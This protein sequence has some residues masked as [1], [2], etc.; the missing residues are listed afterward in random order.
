MLS[1]A[2]FVGYLLSTFMEILKNPPMSLQLKVGTW[3][4]VFYAVF[5]PR[6]TETENKLTSFWI[7]LVLIKHTNNPW[8]GCKRRSYVKVF[9][10]SK[11]ANKFLVKCS[12]HTQI[13]ETY[14]RDTQSW[15]GTHTYNFMWVWLYRVLCFKARYWPVQ[16]T[17]SRS[18]EP[19]PLECMDCI[20]DITW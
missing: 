9:L 5:T 8:C 20:S 1:S 6:L 14:G 13:S 3:I 15:R 4:K 18:G 17:W 2:F 10:I 11:I 16:N 12:Q 7:F 19:K